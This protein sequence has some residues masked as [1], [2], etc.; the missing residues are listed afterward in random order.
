MEVEL[1][2][3]QKMQ[4]VGTLSAGIAHDFNNILTPIIGYTE[5]IMS[6]N[7]EQTQT[8]WM[9]ERILNASHR[10]KELVRQILT[11]S[12]QTEQERKPVQIC[13]VIKEA[14]RLLRASLPTTIEIRQNIISDALVVGDPTQIHQVL[15]NLCT[16][17]GH[18][19]QEKGGILEVS[20]TDANLDEE[21][22]SRNPK[23]TA[24]SYVRLTVS[25][26]GHGMPPDVLERVFDPFF[27]TKE[28]SKGTGMGLSVVHGIVEN[29]GGIISVISKASEGST[30]NV[31]L[32][33]FVDDAAVVIDAATSLPTGSERIL[34]V[35]DELP[36][37]EMSKHILDT[38]GYDVTTRTSSVEA[39]EL[40][41][42]KPDYFDLVITD[43]TMPNMTGDKL[44]KA[45]LHIRPDIP[46]IICTGYSSLINKEK[47]ENMGIRAY[48]M[49]PM[50]TQEL[51][52]TIRNVLG[53][54]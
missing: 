3:A 45:L 35:D 16:N 15:M 21:A 26:T 47:A 46:I 18:A 49:K 28:R 30:F 48:I 2:Q 40:F 23:V 9:M 36:V 24:D 42:V 32:P 5:L 53:N 14:L 4:A 10:A 33:V 38:L 43:M 1:R 34:F 51:A 52:Q 20:L 39:F 31:Y 54:N 29:H 7:M 13:L 27:T 8:K 6:D 11:F 25:D 44:A 22:L 19:M 17:A 12:R 37:V 41:K 50:L